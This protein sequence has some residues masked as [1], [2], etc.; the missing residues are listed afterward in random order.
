MVM[1]ETAVCA[2]L[3]NMYSIKSTLSE[4]H[5]IFPKVCGHNL[6]ELGT[7]WVYEKCLIWGVLRKTLMFP[8]PLCHVLWVF[9]YKDIDPETGIEK[10]QTFSDT[11]QDI[12]PVHIILENKDGIQGSCALFKERTDIT[13]NVRSKTPLLNLQEALER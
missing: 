13:E 7:L 10:T 4:R 6:W 11:R 3:V 12:Y 8:V 5:T 9:R 2:A 1:L